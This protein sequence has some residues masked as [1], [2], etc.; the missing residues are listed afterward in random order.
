VR[1]DPAKV[2]TN[3]VMFDVSETAFSPAAVVEKLGQRGVLGGAIDQARVRL[4]TH[5]DVSRADCQR[6]AAIFLEVLGAGF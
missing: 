1:I 2:Q 5:C 4:V 6:A 3:I